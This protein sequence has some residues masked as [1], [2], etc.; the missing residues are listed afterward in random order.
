MT[1]NTPNLWVV[2]INLNGVTALLK[3]FS[4]WPTNEYSM[5]CYIWGT[6]KT[7]RLRKVEITG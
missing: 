6:A 3:V 2:S 1:E 5:L 7:K 4:D